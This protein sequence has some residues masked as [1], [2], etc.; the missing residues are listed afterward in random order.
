MSV[1]LYIHICIYRYLTY[2]LKEIKKKL[3]RNKHTHTNDENHPHSLGSGF[4][5]CTSV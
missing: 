4:F 2:I 5:L 3:S 1:S